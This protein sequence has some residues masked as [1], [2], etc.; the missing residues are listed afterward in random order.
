MMG[1]L[2]AAGLPRGVLFHVLEERLGAGFRE[3][4]MIDFEIQADHLDTLSKALLLAHSKYPQ[5][6]EHRPVYRLVR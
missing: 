2:R 1:G 4:G 6:H 3:L 5:H